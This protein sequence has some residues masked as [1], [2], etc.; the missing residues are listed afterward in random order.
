MVFGLQK[1]WCSSKIDVVNMTLY[2]GLI[3][4]DKDKK[5]WAFTNIDLIAKFMLYRVMLYQGS[6]IIHYNNF[7]KGLKLLY[8][9]LNIIKAQQDLQK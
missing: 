6:T 9:P 5:N 7:L 4:K 3:N 8:Q 2:W 1:N